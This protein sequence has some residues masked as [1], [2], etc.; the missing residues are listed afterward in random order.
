[1]A[2]TRPACYRSQPSHLDDQEIERKGI[3]QLNMSSMTA[4]NLQRYIDDQVCGLVSF[5]A[6]NP[7]QLAAIILLFLGV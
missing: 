7:E 1:M 6:L 5:A 3:E 4:T 2:H